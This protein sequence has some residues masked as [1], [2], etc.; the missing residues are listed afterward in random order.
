LKIIDSL[1]Q[2]VQLARLVSRLVEDL[3]LSEDTAVWAVEAW[4]LALKVIDKP[5]FLVKQPQPLIQDSQSD[6]ILTLTPGVTLELVR[7]PAGEFLMGGDKEKDYYA[8]DGETP[9]HKVYLEEYLIGKYPV[10]VAQFA[11]F[12]KASKYKTT[13]EK[14]SNGYTWNGFGYEHKP[15]NWQHP[16]GP[17]SNV[18][19]KAVI[20]FPW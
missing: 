1:P 16:R 9:Q 19:Q 13:T 10:T 20:R 6:L 3:G 15:A 5:G 14:E 17:G 8:S 12:V 18:S 4:A 2:E 7:V 11:A